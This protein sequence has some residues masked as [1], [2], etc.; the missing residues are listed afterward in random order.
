MR[1]VPFSFQGEC[2]HG[3]F[4]P[5]M[6]KGNVGLIIIHYSH[7]LQ[8]EIFI[9]GCFSRHKCT[10]ITISMTS[11]RVRV[12]F[13]SDS[14]F[15]MW[16]LHKAIA[17]SYVIAFLGIYNVTEGK[18]TAFIQGD[19]T[20]VKMYFSKIERI[21]NTFGEV[22]SVH[23]FSD[24]EGKLI[25]SIGTFR[26]N[27]IHKRKGADISIDDSHNNRTI[28]NNDVIHVDINAFGQEDTSAIT[29]ENLQGIIRRTGHADFDRRQS[30][31]CSQVC[32]ATTSNS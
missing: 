29:R 5:I 21:C 9:I 20:N 22:E 2:S 3:I 25:D 30:I 27:R 17:D 8:Y 12:D 26:P 31:H 6:I 7:Q 19:S 13:A 4:H 1:I 11:I 15:T 14:T 23:K 10:Y 32:R 18:V 24:V 28:K 16:D